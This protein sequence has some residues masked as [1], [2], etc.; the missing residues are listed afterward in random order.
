MFLA[1]SKHSPWNLP[2]LCQ[3]NSWNVSN[4]VHW[5][6]GSGREGKWNISLCL[7]YCL[8]PGCPTRCSEGCFGAT[9]S[10]SPALARIGLSVSTQ[11]QRLERRLQ[12]VQPVHCWD[13]WSA[14]WSFTNHTALLRWELI[15]IRPWARKSLPQPLTSGVVG[16]CMGNNCIGQ[17]TFGGQYAELDT[18]GQNFKKT[19]VNTNTI[20]L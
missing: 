18:S 16:G 10:H 2:D 13:G 3:Q 20:M 7:H 11:V 6:P 12:M 15:Q 9:S 19:L 17:Q 4:L 5:V 14:V 8:G 1:K